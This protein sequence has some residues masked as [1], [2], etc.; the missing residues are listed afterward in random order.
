MY[1]VC[2]WPLSLSQPTA[3]LPSPPKKEYSSALYLKNFPGFFALWR[4]RGIHIYEYKPQLAFNISP[5]SIMQTSVT[6][7]SEALTFV[8]PNTPP[9]RRPHTNFYLKGQN[10]LAENGW[11]HQGNPLAADSM[12]VSRCAELETGP[13]HKEGQLRERM[14]GD[15]VP[16]TCAFLPTCWNPASPCLSLPLVAL[17]RW[18]SRLQGK[19]NSNQSKYLQHAYN[20]IY[21][22]ATFEKLPILKGLPKFTGINLCNN[23]SDWSETLA[24]IVWDTAQPPTP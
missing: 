23:N 4:W 18:S 10:C 11:E 3:K 16:G 17:V 12:W 22:S 20:L 14:E 9:A 7:L 2:S 21:Q 1:F 5:Y 13:S 6:L 15:P 24:M 19:D 8:T